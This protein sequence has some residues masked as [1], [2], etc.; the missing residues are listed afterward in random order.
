MYCAWTPLLAAVRF[1]RDWLYSGKTVWQLQQQDRATKQTSLRPRLIS[2]S[3]RANQWVVLL[4]LSRN[5]LS[6]VLRSSA[7]WY[8]CKRLRPIDVSQSVRII[9]RVTQTTF[10]LR[11]MYN[12][13]NCSGCQAAGH[14]AGS[15][16]RLK[17]CNHLTFLPV[18]CPRPSTL[19]SCTITDHA[20][21]TAYHLCNPA[22]TSNK[23][24][25]LG[26]SSRL[27]YRRLPYIRTMRVNS[28]R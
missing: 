13:E 9:R 19:C 7:V 14:E 2:F 25:G 8:R 22:H 28:Y 24:S 4:Q 17:R 5:L 21:T 3:V 12:I 20:K 16:N 18:I 11:G 27:Y 10:S 15:T 26:K 23:W 1:N 6:P